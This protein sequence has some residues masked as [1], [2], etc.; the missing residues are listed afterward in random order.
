MSW[1]LDGLKFGGYLTDTI[2]G[3]FSFLPQSPS[4][5]I[6][7]CCK[8]WELFY[9]ATNFN[10]ISFT[11]LQKT[12]LN[13]SVV[14]LLPVIIIHVEVFQQLSGAVLKHSHTYIF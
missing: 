3:V 6:F 12:L 10:S 1:T 8:E 9:Q 5:Y 14:P 4:E 2:V 13:Q 7:P 11:N